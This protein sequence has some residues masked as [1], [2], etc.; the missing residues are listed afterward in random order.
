MRRETN[1]FNLP[2][3]EFINDYYFHVILRD[4]NGKLILPKHINKKD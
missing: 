1:E 2:E 4:S 3:L